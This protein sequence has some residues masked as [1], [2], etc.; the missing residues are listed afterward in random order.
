MQTAFCSDMQDMEDLVREFLLES[1]EGLDR[2][3]HCLG[4]MAEPSA[5]AEPLREIFRAV[6]TIKGA[7]GFLGFERLERVAHAGENLLVKMRDGELHPTPAR[8][9]VLLALLDALRGILQGIE[10]GDGTEPAGEDAPLLAR[11]VAQQET[12]AVREAAPEAVIA[13]APAPPA[14]AKVAVDEPVPAVVQPQ[15]E[16]ASAANPNPATPVDSADN[17]TATLAVTDTTVRVDVE[18]L[19]QLLN[20]AGELVL[21]R[22]QIVAAAHG[23]AMETLAQRLHR[24]TGEIRDAVMRVRMQPVEQ[25]FARF[26]RLVR[27]L[28]RQCGKTVRLEME[29]Q[30]TR[31][32]R[33]VLEMIRDPLLH[34]IRNA[35]DHGIE[36]PEVR[37]ARG[38]PQEGLLRLRA[39]S[40]G[41]H[42]LIEI[43]DDGGGMAP[44][45]LRQ[46]AVNKGLLTAE[47]AAALSDA[48]ARNLVFLPG[49]S[50]AA[51]VTNVSGRGVGLDV[52][53]QNVE[54]LGGN[55]TLDSKEGVGTTIRLRLPLTLAILPALIVRCG[56]QRFAVPQKSVEELLHR[57]G[58]DWHREVECM[59]TV[60]LLRLRE[61]L[62]PLVHLR[63]LL[64][65]PQQNGQA[66]GDVG[67]NLVVLNAE[68]L[69][70][71]LC[72][73]ALE[74]V[75][76]LVVRPL[77]RITEADVFSG[78]AQLADG[79]L[80]LIL[81]V[82]GLAALAGVVEVHAGSEETSDSQTAV[83]QQYLHVEL[84]GI[85]AVIPIEHVEHVMAVQAA[86]IVP[87]GGV[88]VMQAG[89][90]VIPLLDGVRSGRGE[91]VEALGRAAEAPAPTWNVLL[92]NSDAGR[93]GL[94]VSAIHGM[95][96]AERLTVRNVERPE[97]SAQDVVRLSDGLARIIS[98]EAWREFVLHPED[99]Q[100][101]NL[102]QWQ[103]Q[104]A[105]PADAEAQP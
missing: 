71:G 57:G 22:N 11:L 55:V 69:R 66:A 12:E 52:V 99:W 64:R 34:A 41:D 88:L 43:S 95:V 89:E 42:V 104:D 80:V 102:L 83:Q 81:D 21:T 61:R 103:S 31:L 91:G 72:V 26:P 54:R 79:G 40:A 90:D 51:Q 35:I 30:Q 20:L 6:H 58:A 14:A 44:E 49:F 105:N 96:Q 38:K 10:Q 7:T 77:D 84:R 67:E 24:V 32:D 19:Q 86:S 59:G 68:A 76:E 94:L 70:F 16:S 9:D 101:L 33:S 4:Q 97:E 62:L 25:V 2:M 60:Q 63:A 28:A 46:S 27:E 50:T 93:M 39:S 17:S 15:M 5:G 75:E 53:R 1:H 8:M 23:T 87:M 82:A 85:P 78:A 73:D 45:R 65:L 13:A 36:L 56:G 74:G 37:A 47:Q 98:P 100:P 48:E 18:V 29:G 3:E 92:C